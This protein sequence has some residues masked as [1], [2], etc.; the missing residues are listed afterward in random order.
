M[1]SVLPVAS[2]YERGKEEE[3]LATIN[4]SNRDKSRIGY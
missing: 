3:K 1:M 4:L 2:N